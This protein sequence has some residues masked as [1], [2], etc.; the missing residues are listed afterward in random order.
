MGRWAEERRLQQVADD[1]TDAV[2][3]AIS[4]D[5]PINEKLRRFYKSFRLPGGAAEKMDAIDEEETEPILEAS[6]RIGVMTR[7]SQDV[8]PK[9]AWSTRT[10]VASD[11]R[12]RR[13]CD[14]TTERIA[15]DRAE[16]ESMVGLGLGRTFGL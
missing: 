9:N 1:A 10:R 14:V 5:R 11:D 13:L 15:A 8:P 16:E 2:A 3:A 4:F 7:P 6:S 12:P